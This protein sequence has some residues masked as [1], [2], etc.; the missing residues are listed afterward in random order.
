MKILFFIALYLT[1]INV[2]TQDLLLP[3][4][5]VPGLP[6][7]AFTYPPESILIRIESITGNYDTAIVYFESSAAKSF[8]SSLYI[9][10]EQFVRG[11]VK[12][13]LALVQSA[14]NQDG[15]F[16]IPVLNMIL[17]SFRLQYKETE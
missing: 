6:D 9:N 12:M 8:D 10:W 17:L 11:R 13:P 15:S 5:P 14:F 4:K 1:S 2:F 7:S 3:V 16:N